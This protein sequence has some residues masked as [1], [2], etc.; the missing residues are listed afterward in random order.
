MSFPGSFRFFALLL[1]AAAMGAEPDAR[2]VKLTAIIGAATDAEDAMA[3]M[4]EVWKRDRWFTF[5]KFR[6][7]TE[8][9]AAEMKRRG[10]RG[11]EVLAAPA[12]GRTQFGFWTMPLAWDARAARLEIVG[13]PVLADYRQAPASLGMWSGP[14]PPGG[15]EAGIVPFG[16]A[17]MRGK[18]VL[19]DQNAANLKWRLVKGGALGAI[20]AFT[21]NPSL[22]DGRQ[23]VNAWGDKGWGLLKGDA[24]LLSFSITP[25]QA[26][27][28]RARLAKGP[29]RARAVVD[30]RIFEGE[31]PYVTGVMRG[32]GREE[33]LTLG[34]IAEQG[35][36]DN[37]T[38]VAAMVAALSTLETLIARGQLARPRR[39]IRMLAMGELY[40][41]MHYLAR[42]P[43]RVRNTVAAMTLDTPAAPYEMKGTEYTFHLN[44]HVASSYVDA[45]ILKVAEA[46]L[47]RLAPPRPFHWKP[48][49]PGT[50]SFL[51]EPMIGIPT[52]WPYSGTG[53]H[54]H[55]NSEDKPE[56]VDARSLRD[57]IVITAAYL[58]TIASAGEGDV[59]WLAN[60][61]ADRAAEQI[62]LAGDVAQ[63]NY[64]QDR[65]TQAVRSV[66][67]LGGS[68]SRIR[69]AIERV[70]RDGPEPARA[71]GMVVRRKRMGSMTLD[72]LPQEK[73]EGFPSGAWDARAQLAL[74]WCDG[75]RTLEEVIRLTKLEAGETD[76]DFVSYFRFL[77]RHGYVE[78]ME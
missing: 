27:D 23:W 20:N 7:T 55:H 30:S 35:A 32:V 26:D 6:E 16:G 78:I 1:A 19:C 31:Y 59:E 77:A 66:L 4:R 14:T 18:L 71:K 22:R 13:G 72:D 40:C 76:F 10:L 39:G 57:L 53:V 46:H 51:G 68:E 15:V 37:A 70:R 42:N 75:K 45:L 74:F 8:Y 61:A 49:T 69:A 58:Y 67:R 62:A 44:P 54:T 33:V 21:E 43:E 52:V 60:M 65:G 29:V 25:A 3:V 11:V 64:R 36:H 41:T 38:G 34:H 24:P 63:R 47:S 2:L 12:D 9:L 50:D 48:F 56:T 17:D 73:R 5:P 28:L